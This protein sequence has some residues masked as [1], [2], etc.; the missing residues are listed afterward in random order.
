MFNN[1]TIGKKIYYPLI[2]GILLGVIIMS[3]I[4]Y[5]STKK[6]RKEVF[7]NTANEL[8]LLF[9]LKMEAKKDVGITNAITIANNTGVIKALREND[10]SY[11]YKV[12]KRLLKEYKK[13]TKFKNIKIHI[14][15]KDV[16]SFL[17]VWKPD[18]YG[19]DLSGFR[20]T[21]VWVKNNKR[22]LV[23]IEL[24]RAG[25]V[26]RGL[27]PVI[28]SGV[29][30]GSVEFM[31]GLNSIAKDLKKQNIYTL[32]IFKKEYLNIAKFLKTAPEI[33]GNYVLALKKGAYDEKFFEELKNAKL[34]NRIVTKA[35]FS[36]SV[37]I[38]DFSSKVVAYA[39]IGKPMEYVQGAVKES[40]NNLILQL[41][42]MIAINVLII[43]VL[44]YVVSKTVVVYANE[45]KDRVEDLAYGEG[46]LTKRITIKTN[47]E[48]SRIAKF[49]NIFMEKLQNIINALKTLIDNTVNVTDQTDKIAEKVKKAVN[50]QNE[51]LQIAKEHA[52]TIQND[53]ET[54]QYSVLKTAE[55]I[56]DTQKVLESFVNSL[57]EMV[58]H[59]QQNANKEL[60]ISSKITMLA[61][62]S[63][64]IKEIINIIKEIA[65][66]TNL[67][68]LNAAIEAARAGEHGR[69]FAVVAD[70]VRKLAERTQ[71]SLN[72][73]DSA[74][75]IIVQGIM[76][77][78]NEINT[79]ARD[80]EHLSSIASSLI[81]QSSESMSKLQNTI[82]VSQQAKEESELIEKSIKN[83]VEIIKKV[84]TEA[85]NSSKA[86][87]ELNE[88]VKKLDSITNSLKKEVNNFK[89]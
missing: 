45:L 78:Q 36:V 19:D 64:Q 1:L 7:Q 29:Y 52:K 73:I 54:T 77:A 69:G 38:K 76:D 89:T 67:L 68:A 13:Y 35:F 50:N 16:K 5:S 82:S 56:M 75:N 2:A 31:Q 46:D 42:F 25:L 32:I 57:N 58:E 44:M 43:I 27:A 49:I 26:L 88:I 39:I 61:D 40:E 21:I 9:K 71:K 20:K 41:M 4:S 18:K 8:K 33:M 86:V 14:H 6:I 60:E 81:N 10:R 84:N 3:L 87:K 79:N 59:I 70:E 28:D 22:P 55:D 47:D 51:Y 63:N 65:D 17:R 85:E 12:L 34:N 37:P 66:Q 30:L 80:S 83:L 24:G 72:E 11:A 15:T 23:A 62:Q 48:I 74:I 53:V